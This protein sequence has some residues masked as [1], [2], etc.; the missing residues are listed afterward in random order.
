MAEFTPSTVP[1]CR[2]PHFPI[3]NGRSLY[4]ALGPEFTLLR[5]DPSLDVATLCNAAASRKLP[6]RVLDI[7]GAEAVRLYDHKLVLARPDQHIAWR[8][9]APPAAADELIALVSGGQP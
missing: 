4:D 1:G 8:G 6:L 5:R 3:G 7:G 2:L 9:D